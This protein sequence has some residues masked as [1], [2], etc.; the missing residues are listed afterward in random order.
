MCS[1]SI[2]ENGRNV[3]CMLWLEH[4]FILEL[5][6][7]H[8]VQIYNFAHSEVP[9][10]MDLEPSNRA[11]RNMRDKLKRK[12][13]EVDGDKASKKTKQLQRDS[14]KSFNYAHWRELAEEALE[15]AIKFFVGKGNFKKYKKKYQKLWGTKDHT[16]S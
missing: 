2:A 13:G 1:F 6:S 16:N 12:L 15:P 8:D 3:E 5:Y 11:Q 10:V 7:L 9:A 14:C 4:I